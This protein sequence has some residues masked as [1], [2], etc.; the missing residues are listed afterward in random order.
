MKYYSGVYNT[1]PATWFKKHVYESCSIPAKIQR[2]EPIGL[3]NGSV[4][5]GDVSERPVSGGALLF[6]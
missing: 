4:P 5:C 2:I 6:N 1:T 3:G